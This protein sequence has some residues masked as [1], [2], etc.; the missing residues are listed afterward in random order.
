MTGVKHKWYLAG[1]QNVYNRK[2][3]VTAQS[4]IEQRSGKTG[5][6]RRK[7]LCLRDRCGGA[8][9]DRPGLCEGRDQIVTSNPFILD[10]KDASTAQRFG[11]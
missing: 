8:N 2:D 5:L 7:L 9:G 11:F 3:V 1:S 6:I 4:A 10:N